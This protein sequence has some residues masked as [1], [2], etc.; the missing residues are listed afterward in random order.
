MP[1]GP[2]GGNKRLLK[3]KRDETNFSFQF[4]SSETSAIL[5]APCNHSQLLGQRA[6]SGKRSRKGSSGII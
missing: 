2:V 4:P 1:I 3:V 5:V 6:E